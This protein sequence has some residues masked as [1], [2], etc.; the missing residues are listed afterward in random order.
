M[1]DSVKVAHVAQEGSAPR[2]AGHR[3]LHNTI[4]LC[5]ECLRELK[6]DV[7]A[8]DEGTVWM[9]RTCPDHGPLTTRVWPDADHYQW[10]LSEAF[11]KTKPQNTIPASAP[12]PIGCGTCSRHER[13]GTLLG[14]GLGKLGF[15]GRPV[16]V[17]V[18]HRVRS[19][20]G[21]G[22]GECQR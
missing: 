5:P 6:A 3:H 7:Y 11:P 15:Q 22:E 8:D 20:G 4:G 21:D 17:L 12:C 10:L 1:N 19:V 9:E 14:L 18:F 16:K 13:R 2:V